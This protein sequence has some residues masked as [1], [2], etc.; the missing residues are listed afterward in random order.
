MNMSITY[1]VYPSTPASLRIYPP[2]SPGYD[3]WQRTAIPYDFA[4]KERGFSAGNT[5]F[6]GPSDQVLGRDLLLCAG[7][8]NGPSASIYDETAW[9]FSIQHSKS[10]RPSPGYLRL[11]SDVAGWDDRKKGLFSEALATGLTGYALWNYDEVVHIADAGPFIGR[12]L[13]GPNVGIS[14]VSLRS[15]GIYGKNGGYKPDFF[16]ITKTGESVIVEVKGGIGPPSCI[17]AA[18]TKGKQ[19]VKNVD[20]VGVPERSSNSRLVFAANLRYEHDNPRIGKDTTLTVVDPERNEEPL[21]VKLSTDEVV[22]DSYKSLFR[23]CSREDLIY[24]FS[25]STEAILSMEEIERFSVQVQGF[26]I[27]PLFASDW[28]LIGLF[29]PAA[30][31]LLASPRDS[32]AEK[33]NHPLEMLWQKREGLSSDSDLIILPNGVVMSRNAIE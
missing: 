27:Y 8:L 3:F 17:S 21:T 25:A 15:L 4:L 11:N 7:L 29:E 30:R 9:G 26:P 24:A 12:A 23:F 2:F 22:R 32:I 20:P 6:P 1:K 5:Y 33:M 16:C 14:D 28:L 18:I 10:L 13:A 19:Q 31:V